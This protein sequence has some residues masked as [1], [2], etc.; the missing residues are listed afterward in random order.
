ML[1]S[2]DLPGKPRVLIA[3]D[4][5]I[6]RAT[7]IKHIEGMFDFREALDG[8]QAW[9]TLLIDPSIRVVITDLT[10]PKLDGYGLLHRIR[11]SKISRIRTIP[12]VVVSGSDEREERERAKAAGATDLI[13]KGI[14]TAQLLSRL[15]IL[16]KLVNTQHDFE[17]SLESLA[18]VNA[19]DGALPVTSLDEVLV[20]AGS[21]LETAVKN[22]KNF[23]ILNVSVGFKHSTLRGAATTPP[24]SVI[25]AIGHVLQRTVRESDHVARTDQA[26]FTLITGSINFDSAHLFAER[27]CRAIGNANMVKDSP[28]ALIASCGVG[29]LAEHEGGSGVTV[30]LLLKT[31]KRRAAMGMAHAVTGVVGKEEEAALQNNTYHSPAENASSAANVP[32]ATPD[33]ATLLQWIK[34]GKH[35]KVL[36]YIGTLSA[37]LQPLVDLVLKKG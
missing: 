14:G 28:M 5:R 3:D 10:M 33:L 6:V 19:T 32:S 34:E 22:G 13:T 25:D 15:D 17:R 8:E 16:S 4:S 23:V 20:Q 36:P 9:E 31:A 7:L 29:T 2:T 37:E 24:Q 18:R 30:D 21:M 35:D 12:V 1:S 11:N 26:E 27:V